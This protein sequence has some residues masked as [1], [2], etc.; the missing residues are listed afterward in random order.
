MITPTTKTESKH[1]DPARQYILP[2]VL[3]EFLDRVE[4][5]KEP[6]GSVR[7]Q[8]I[9]EMG[10]LRSA[11]FIQGV[12][13]WRLTPLGLEVQD[14]VLG[15][16]SVPIAALADIPTDRLLG[17]D[18]A[19]SGAVEEIA[20]GGGIEF[21][22]AAV[23][24]TSA[25]TGDVTKAA[26]GTATT[27][28]ADAVTFAKMQNIATKK[29]I[30]RYSALTGDPEEI[31]FNYG[32][33]T[34][35]LTNVANLDAST[36]YECQYIRI[37]NVVH[38]SGKVDIDPTTTLTSTQLGI[39]LPI[40]SNF[41]AAEDCAGT[42]SASGIAAQSAAILADAANDRAQLQYVA[43]DVTNQPMYFTFTYQII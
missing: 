27:I 40:A 36:A 23:I 34:P 18:A 22:G 35:T 19:G 16:G 38:V 20:V 21:S 29:L 14:L 1:F 3:F 9:L 13:G 10:E 31:D 15:A 5:V 17:R 25:F 33:Y 8:R 30:G 43:S 26:G 39:S 7:N 41:G 12:A 37:G 32:V 6:L 28:A 2:P 24:Q 4:E 11:N 42:A